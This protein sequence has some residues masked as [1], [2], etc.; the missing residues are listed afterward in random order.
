MKRLS[1]F[2]LLMERRTSRPYRPGEDAMWTFEP[3]VAR[4]P[5]I[6]SWRAKVS[7]D[8]NAAAPEMAPAVI[9]NAVLKS[10]WRGVAG[11]IV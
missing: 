1:Q 4:G 6:P 2:D 7:T 11:D 9:L 3:S 8:A 10:G 5:I